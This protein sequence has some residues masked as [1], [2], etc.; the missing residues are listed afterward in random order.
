[1]MKKFTKTLFLCAGIVSSINVYAENEITIIGNVLDSTCT[2]TTTG[3]TG[4]TNSETGDFT[5]ALPNIL[6]NEF[7]ENVAGE[8]NVVFRLT[9]AGNSSESCDPLTG[10]TLLQ[11]MML[12][13][14]LLNESTTGVLVNNQFTGDENKRVD[15]QVLTNNNIP[16]E[17]NNPLQ[18]KSDVDGANTDPT[19]TY[20][21]R[22]FK[23]GTDV[24][25][26]QVEA[27]MTYTLNYN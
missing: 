5:I 24:D 6:S 17:F 4:N 27:K 14:N 13:A 2:L 1:M 16:V 19:M 9:Q 22:Y 8:Q 15:I 7:N 26:Q 11:G 20:K 25:A 18:A 12:S 23:V 21:V 3:A 10:T